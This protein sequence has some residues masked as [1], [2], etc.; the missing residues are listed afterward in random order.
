MGSQDMI[1]TLLAASTAIAT[2]TFAGGASAATYDAFT[3][4]DGTQGAG[5]FYYGLA[6]SANPG[7]SGTFFTAN[8]NCFIDNSVCLQQAP[9]H[10][11]PG[12]A[13]GG[14]PEFQYG[15]VIVP[16][17]RLL[18]HPGDNSLQTF[19]AFVAPTAGS[20]LFTATFNVQDINP[21]GVNISLIQTTD[22]HLPLIFS[23]LG[24]IGAQNPVYTYSGRFNLTQ[25][26][27]LGFGID[28]AGQYFNDSTGVNLSVT[29]VPEPA[30]WALIIVGFGAIGAT[31]RRRKGAR[32]SHSLA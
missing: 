8:T 14:S 20:Y 15:S 17:D 19:L 4:F 30:S 27:A 7:N 16:Q 21:T 9:N 2:L 23:P 31:Q 26:Q 3:S 11:V 6:D 24:S 18:A 25:S 1:R 22:A 13:K 12:F 28:N 29:A 32:M 5:N 10:D